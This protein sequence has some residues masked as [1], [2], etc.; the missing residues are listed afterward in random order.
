MQVK[1][2]GMENFQGAGFGKNDLLLVSI[3]I[4]AANKISVNISDAL[5]ATFS[6]M[7]LNNKVV[8]CNSINY[9]S[10]LVTGFFL[11]YETMV[12]LLIINRCF[13]TVGSQLPHQ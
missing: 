1:S 7:S 11:S 8:S 2:L 12:E 5:R 13:P 3:T 9:D 6:K 10:D 4:R